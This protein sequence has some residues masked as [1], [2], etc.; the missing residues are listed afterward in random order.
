LGSRHVQEPTLLMHDRQPIVKHSATGPAWK[1]GGSLN[2]FVAGAPHPPMHRVESNV[3]LVLCVE[4]L[5]LP[6][7]ATVGSCRTDTIQLVAL[8]RIS[9]R[10]CVHNHAI[11]LPVSMVSGYVQEWVVN[12]SQWPLF[13]TGYLLDLPTYVDVNPNAPGNQA[14]TAR[15]LWNSQA[16][17]GNCPDRAFKYHDCSVWLSTFK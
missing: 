2:T 14:L 13:V 7:A 1:E 11:S 6:A 15:H 10:L 12:I 9:S 3:K 17:T 16:H 8:V 4:G 5:P